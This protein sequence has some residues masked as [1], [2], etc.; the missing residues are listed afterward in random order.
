M[1]AFFSLSASQMSIN[2]KP[3]RPLLAAC[4]YQCTDPVRSTDDRKEKKHRLVLLFPPGSSMPLH[5]ATA[6]LFSTLEYYYTFIC[7]LKSR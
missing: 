6:S 1:A 4:D 2:V 5:I 7:L 3:Q